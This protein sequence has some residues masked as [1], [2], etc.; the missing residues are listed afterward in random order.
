MEL[1]NKRILVTGGAGFI[2]SHLVNKLIDS[3]ARVSIIDD[4]STGRRENVNPKATFHH[5]DM[6]A[7][8]V[9]EI[10]RKEKPEI[11]YHLAFNT[12]V[13]QS[14]K[15]PLFD[16]R[17][18]SGSLN[19][20]LASV[21]T[22]VKKV[23]MASSAFIY[24]N[25]DPSLLPVTEHH[26]P[27]PVSPY[28][29]SKI[30]SENYLR[31]FHNTH[32]LPVVIL[33]YS[34]VYGP[35]QVTG[36]LADYIRKISAGR[37]AQMFGDGNLT[38]DYI[39]VDDVVRANFLALDVPDNHPEPIFNLGTAYERTLNDV[40]KTVATLLG[41]PKNRPEY[42]PARPGD[43]IRFSVSSEKARRQLGWEASVPFEKGV[44]QL[45]TSQKKSR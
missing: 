1:K 27:Q 45:L 12:S 2:G 15:D 21:E 29:I 36:A 19:I 3:G 26:E 14:V 8:E 24:G 34:T 31:Y 41:K 6:N 32:N 23:V 37:R 7:K 38:R 16:A 13:P 28:A 42:L 35:G 40:Y 43:I 10:F 30:T 44:A 17:G 33:R 25:C 20:F 22:G 9:P 18:I 5:M 39:H 4:L 11:V